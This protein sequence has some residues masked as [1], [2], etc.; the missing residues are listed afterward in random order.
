MEISIE[1]C[2]VAMESFSDEIGK[3]A[4]HCEW[5]EV[6][7]SNPSSGVIL[8]LLSIFCAIGNHCLSRPG[9]S[10]SA[11]TLFFA[12]ILG[13]FYKGTTRVMRKRRLKDKSYLSDEIP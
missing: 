9:N 11:V 10:L 3:S 4:Y 1:I 2:F 5:A 8:M 12:S 6:K 13:N 7:S